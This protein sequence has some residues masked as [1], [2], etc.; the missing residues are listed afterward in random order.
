[1]KPSPNSFIVSTDFGKLN[2]KNNGN[3]LSAEY[4][5]SVPVTIT[6]KWGTI[7]KNVEITV[8]PTT[9]QQN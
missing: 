4:Q 9:G 6:Y 2:Y 3:V 7:K 8:H 1:M 5:I